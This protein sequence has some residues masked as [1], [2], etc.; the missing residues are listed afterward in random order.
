MHKEG[1]QVRE[2]LDTWSAERLGVELWADN[3]IELLGLV[4]IHDRVQPGPN[5][6]PYWWNSKNGE[7]RLRPRVF[8]QRQE[9]RDEAKHWR[10]HPNWESRVRSAW[11]EALED[12]AQDET[13]QERVTRAA[14]YLDFGP[15]LMWPIFVEMGLLDTPAPDALEEECRSCNGSGLSPVP[16]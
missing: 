4:S 2:R 9:E 1:W 16:E 10:E 15:L 12:G 13:P 14:N 3:P 11:A 8:A 5:P 6:E 7:E